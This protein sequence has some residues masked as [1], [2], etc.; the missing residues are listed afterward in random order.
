MDLQLTGCGIKS[1]TKG[2]S[3]NLLPI[4]NP[5]KLVIDAASL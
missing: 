1:G 2:V 4:D 3:Y 5:R